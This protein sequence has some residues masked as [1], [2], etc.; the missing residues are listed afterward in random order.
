MPRTAAQLRT[1]AIATGWFDG[2]NLQYVGDGYTIPWE[3]GLFLGPPF[4]FTLL[5]WKRYLDNRAL[6]PSRLHDWLYTPYGPEL[7]DCTQEEADLALKEEMLSE[8]LAASQVE[9][10][11]QACRVGGSPYFGVSSVGYVQPFGQLVGTISPQLRLWERA[12]W[13]HS[14]S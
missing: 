14:R 3:T 4:G 13:H 9:V 1:A 6:E 2:P 10:V 8:G 12:T 5:T 11:Y 7:I